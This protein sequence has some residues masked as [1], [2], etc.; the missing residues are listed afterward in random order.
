[1]GKLNVSV[2]P[3]EPALDQ[4]G[5]GAVPDNDSDQPGKMQARQWNHT[6]CRSDRREGNHD[7]DAHHAKRDKGH[8]Q[9]WSAL[10]KRDLRRLDVNDQGLGHQTLHKPAGLKVALVLD[11]FG[12]ENK[13]H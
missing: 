3:Y 6:K 2:A 8:G 9:G 4:L 5:E 10:E 13:P 12:L 1:M 7:A 11:A